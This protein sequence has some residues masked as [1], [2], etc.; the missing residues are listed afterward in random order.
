MKKIGQIILGFLVALLLFAS[1]DGEAGLEG[2]VI[3][4]Q[5]GERLNNVPLPLFHVPNKQL[6]PT[7]C[8]SQCLCRYIHG[9]FS[10][11]YTTS[12]I[13]LLPTDMVQTQLKL[14]RSSIVTSNM[15]RI[16]SYHQPTP[17]ITSFKHPCKKTFFSFTNHYLPTRPALL[18]P[19]F[20][21]IADIEL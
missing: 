21:Y 7:E 12:W 5:T 8:P 3:N 14:R 2:V 11:C 13:Y 17:N 6:E 10:P 9:R 16:K 1:C 20:L 4:S 18:F 15:N 19:A